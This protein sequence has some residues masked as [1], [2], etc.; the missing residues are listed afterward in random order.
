MLARRK[1]PFIASLACAWLALGGRGLAQTNAPPSPAAADGGVSAPLAADAGAPGQAP[2]LVADGGVLV[3][4]DPPPVLAEPPIVTEPAPE[5]TSQDLSAP[6]ETA[7]A[8]TPEA[9]V[10]PEGDVMVVTAQFRKQNPQKTPVTM[11]VIGGDKMTERSQVTIADLAQAPN[12]KLS[13]GSGSFGPSLQAHIRG[14]GQHDFNF[15]LE[16]GI[17]V[18]VD[19]VYY[20]TLT[21]SIIDLLD[22]ERVEVLRGPQGTLTGQNSI[23]GAIRMYSKL[24]QGGNTG[25]VNVL[26]GRYNRTEVRAAGDFTIVDKK[27][28]ARISGVG[29]Q[30]DGYVTRYDYACAHPGSGV[31]TYQN[32]RGCTLGTEGGRSYAGV[33]TS[34]RW[35]PSDRV[36]V[37]L[38]GD[39]TK[40][41][42]EATPQTLLHVGSMTGPGLPA[43]PPPGPNVQ[44]AGI[45]LG[46]ADGSQFISYSPFRGGQ[47]LDP[48]TKSP[49]A[50]Y[51][52]YADPNP[53]DGSNP[54]SIPPV[55]RVDSG[56]ASLKLD[57]DLT[58]KL[59]LTAI[60][61]YRQYR[62]DW[63]V[64]EGTPVGTY[65]L[66]NV[67][68]NRQGSAELRLTG[69]LFRDYVDFTVGGFYLNRE[70]TYAG[71]ISLRTAQFIEDDKIP[72]MTGAVFTNIEG[73]VTDKLD[74]VAGVRYTYQS[75]EFHYGRDFVQG[76]VINPGIAGL[77]GT[78]GK[79][80]GDRVDYRGALQY[81]W[82]PSLMTYAQVASGFKG[83]GVNPRPLVPDQALPHKP[84]TLIA[85]E[86][87]AKSE[88]FGRKLRTNV[89]GF[90]NQYNDILM[91][92]AMCPDSVVVAPCFL[93]LNAG[94]ANVAGAELE[95]VV[96]P[97]RG[98]ELEGSFAY[99]N[100]KYR[101]I[102]S[103]GA[104][105]GITKDMTAPYAPAWQ[106]SAGARYMI[107]MGSAGSL[108]PRLD[109]IYQD[110]FYTLPTNTSFSEVDSRLVLNGRLTWMSGSELWEAALEVTNITNQLYYF[111][112]RDDRASTYTVTGQPAPPIRWALSLRR[113][114]L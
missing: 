8:A 76:A 101:S 26:Y 31:P 79:F 49:Y 57:V 11:T 19:D 9:E 103:S 109:L 55:Y 35:L 94:K 54:Y 37:N 42:S 3:P 112:V 40:D 113:N 56:G 100:F 96:R 30:S 1:G 65:L 4:A 39:F 89:A 44:I 70:S 92:V 59:V 43:M 86:L 17:G 72:A 114:F 28:F 53:V 73:H 90:L 21:G 34:L 110:S 84:E 51:S 48:Y 12:V 15:A 66:H 6:S 67:V 85:Y 105:S 74:L 24:P 50:N 78:V 77:D 23:G 58:D 29:N 93:P 83:G 71:R 14:V 5:P 46:T 16:P 10:T 102:S 80:S 20:A 41:N 38:S 61:A 106:A 97:L 104:T 60:G 98:L 91:T 64:D 13:P 108:T 32:D 47:A 75:K 69:K 95:A 7:A 2:A 99:L 111:N 22:L 68:G 18:Y 82:L 25:F 88:W 87:G 107:L 62:G 63:S 45:P 33:R 36:E 27:L 81:Q 52:T